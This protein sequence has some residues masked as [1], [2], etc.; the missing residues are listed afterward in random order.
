M[1]TL[2]ALASSLVWGTSDFAGGSFTKRIAAVRV[3]AVAQLGGL[4]VMS[5]LIA[6]SGIASRTRSMIPRNLVLR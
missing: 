5:V 3:V 2:L 1:V 6:A 4:L